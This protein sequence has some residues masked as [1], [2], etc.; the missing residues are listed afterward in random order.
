MPQLVYNLILMISSS[1]FLIGSISFLV[2]D[3]QQMTVLCSGAKS[4]TRA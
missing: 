4:S 2:Y 1:F 3:M